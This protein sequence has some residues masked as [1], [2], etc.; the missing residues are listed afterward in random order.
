MR[1]IIWR[2]SAEFEHEQP[3]SAD[4]ARELLEN[5]NRA[6]A[7]I[8]D[9]EGKHVIRVSREAFGLP[10]EPGESITQT[11]FAAVLGCADARVPTE[12][13]FGQSAN[14]LFVVRV[15][16]NIPGTECLGSLHY[17][18][19]HIPSI[20]LFSVIGHTGCGAVTA[21][22]DA[23]LRPGTY[24]EVVHTPQLRSIV[25]ALLAGVRMASLALNHVHGSEAVA[26]A[27]YR[28]ALIEVSIVANT[29]ITA[30]VLSRALDRPVT[31]GVYDLESR[32]VGAFEGETWVARQF[33]PPADD[34]ALATLLIA[35]AK[36]VSVS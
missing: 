3:T 35:A 9:S 20:E 32:T 28:A 21:A 25:D 26:S 4:A 31:F 8:G 16:G 14:D 23:L 34:E 17:A 33:E 2:E 1:E 29:A 13:I 24:L 10:P 6:F 7:A 19:D 11:P 22:V 18:T 27:G 5:G 36:G 30:S 15:A 12:L